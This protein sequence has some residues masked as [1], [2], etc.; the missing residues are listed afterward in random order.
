MN[1]LIGIYQQIVL[2]ISIYNLFIIYLFIIVRIRIFSVDHD[3]ISFN[4]YN[5]IDFVKKPIVLI[6]NPKVYI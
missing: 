5:L 3:R 4:D 6:T 1:L 2:K